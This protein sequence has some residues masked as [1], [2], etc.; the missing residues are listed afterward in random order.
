MK[1]NLSCQ[2]GDPKPRTGS[3]L[4]SQIDL[5]QVTSMSVTFHRG[6]PNTAPELHFTVLKSCDV[7]NRLPVKQHSAVGDSPVNRHKNLLV[8]MISQESSRRVYE[9]YE[10]CGDNILEKQSSGCF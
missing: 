8:S 1:C 9:V 6:L 3:S 10:I 2:Y 5:P 7:P 4:V